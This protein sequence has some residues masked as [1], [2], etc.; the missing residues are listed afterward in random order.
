MRSSR[1]RSRRIGLL[2]LGAGVE[3][4]V[5]ATVAGDDPLDRVRQDHR[6]LVRLLD[7]G[8]EPGQL[9]Q[10]EH[11]L[12]E[13]PHLVH[14][15]LE[16]LLAARGQLVAASVEHLHRGRERGDGGPQL[17]A[18]VGREPCL[19]LDAILHGVGHVVEGGHQPVEVRV[20]LGFQ[21]GVEA[22]GGEVARGRGD[23]GQRPQ[24]PTTGRPSDG[25]GEQRGHRAAEDQR[26]ADHPQ[27]ARQLGQGEDLE[28][29]GVELGEV[30]PD[31]QVRLAVQ[32]VA[33][34][35]GPAGQDL[36]LR[37]RPAHR[38]G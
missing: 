25:G 13:A 22:A 31:R 38:P 32:D 14:D 10:V 17:V 18:D 15:H 30:H 27:A 33:L 8:L 1:R 29:L 34:A 5:G 19:T 20:L 3:G 37:T 35:P 36:G 9:Q 2:G 6:L 7:A 12:V 11:H 16:R 4:D 24:H 21:P 26:A 23:A 28:V